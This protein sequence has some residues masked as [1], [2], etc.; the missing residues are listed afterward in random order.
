[1][2][3]RKKWEEKQLYGRF[4]RKINDCLHEKTWTW[5]RKGNFKRETESLRIAAQNNVIRTNQIKV[6]I[7]KPVKLRLKIDFVSYPARAEG[8]VN[9]IILKK[10]VEREKSSFALFWQHE[11]QLCST[12]YISRSIKSDETHWM[13]KINT[14]SKDYL[15]DVH[16]WP[17]CFLGVRTCQACVADLDN[18]LWA[19]L[20]LSNH[21]RSEVVGCPRG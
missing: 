20:C 6:R 19:S 15:P 8:L 13:V 18:V 5:L 12:W 11:T 2:I 7:D 21:T 1:M 16:L 10:Y 17:C 9:M 4:K 14:L 3:T